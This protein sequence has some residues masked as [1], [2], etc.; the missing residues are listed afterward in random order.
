ML[1]FFKYSLIFAPIHLSQVILLL[2]LTILLIFYS[3]D[4]VHNVYMMQ[5]VTDKVSSGHRCAGCDRHDDEACHACAHDQCFGVSPELRAAGKNGQ[6]RF[7]VDLCHFWYVLA[8][9]KS[10]YFYLKK[11]QLFYLIS[12]LSNPEQ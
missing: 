2:Y 4:Y 11:I 12:L 7:E 9:T 10:L 1:L 5:N 3:F 8:Q 6:Q